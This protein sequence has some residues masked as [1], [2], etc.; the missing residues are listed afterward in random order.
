[1]LVNQSKL[2]L[3]AVIVLSTIG[4]CGGGGGSAAPAEEETLPQGTGN[5]NTMPA[6]TPTETFTYNKILGEYSNQ[7]WDTIALAKIVGSNSA[8]TAEYIQDVSSSL[9]ERGPSYDIYAAGQT[10]RNIAVDYSWTI[11][12]DNVDTT[13]AVYDNSGMQTANSYRQSANDSELRVS[14]YETTWLAAQGIEYIDG[15]AAQ[16]IYNGNDSIHTLPMIYGDFTQS[17]DLK[18]TATQEFKISPDILF[19]YWESD[20]TTSVVLIATGSGNITID[21]ASST[22]TGSIV[23]DTYYAYDEV[24]GGGTDYSPVGGISNITMTLVNGT[25]VDGQI[26]APVDTSVVVTSNGTISGEGYLKGALFGPNGDE[27][28]A[29]VFVLQD[30]DDTHSYFYWDASGV[31]LGR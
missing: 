17:G 13:V 5:T 1:M 30:S 16:I 31:L 14:S 4:G 7:Q 8:L 6:S 10:D 23:L 25:I 21:Y 15:A 26:T 24:I 20:R 2:F 19:E 29:T 12:T 9:T 11:N 18:A 28:G 22:V 27:L 3:F